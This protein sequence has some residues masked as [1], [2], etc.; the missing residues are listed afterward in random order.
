M[1]P[2]GAPVT[3][4]N[5]AHHSL[6]GLSANLKDLLDSFSNLRIEGEPAP[7]DLS[8]PPPCPISEIPDEILSEILLHLAIIDL[9]S[10]A[11]LAQVCKRLAYLVT[12]EDRIWKRIALG[13]EQGFAA[14]HYD[15]ACQVDGKPLGD[16]GEGGYVLGSDESDD[17]LDAA[18]TKQPDPVSLTQLSTQPTVPS[19][20]TVPASASMARTSA[21]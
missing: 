2:S 4:P 13:P 5:T 1:N 6:E 18:A 15:F 17:I 19:F 11:R 14:M 21:R 20:G 8:P 9:P 16:D 3:V 7:T 12:T 10:F